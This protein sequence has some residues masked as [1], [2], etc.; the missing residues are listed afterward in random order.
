MFDKAQRIIADFVILV[1]ICAALGALTGIACLLLMIVPIYDEWGSGKLLFWSWMGAMVGA[2][3]GA[4]L[5][6]VLR[7]LLLRRVPARRVALYAPLGTLAGSYV[8]LLMGWLFADMTDGKGIFYLIGGA[9]PGVIITAV[10]LHVRY[11]ARPNV[12][13]S[14][15]PAEPT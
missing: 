10:V 13:L 1:S 9:I 4:L 14:F 15:Y 6:P 3:L 8:S 12:D 5:G 7:L 11:R 2:P